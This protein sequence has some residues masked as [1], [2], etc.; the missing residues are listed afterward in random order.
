MNTQDK[1]NLDRT[2]Q[3]I[4]APNALS[5]RSAG[6]LYEI[7]IRGHLNSIWSEYLEGL[8]MRW[9]D[10]GE[11]ILFGPIVDQAALMGI[12]NKLYRLNLSLISVNP[13]NQK[14]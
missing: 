5:S 2:P 4:L 3:G 8:N 7:R 12:L 1:S 11:V 6:E 13:I 10:N 14:K 9:L